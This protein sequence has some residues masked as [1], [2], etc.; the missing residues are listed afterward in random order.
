MDSENIHCCQLCHSEFETGDDLSLHKCIDIKQEFQDSTVI[1]AYDVGENDDIELSEE[2]LSSIIKQVEDLCDSI[3]KG[4]PITERAI[5]VNQQLIDAVGSYRDQL[6]LIDSKNVEMQEDNWDDFDNLPQESEVESGKNDSDTEYKPRVKNK[7]NKLPN[8]D[9][10]TPTSKVDK[11]TVTKVSTVNNKESDE[12]SDQNKTDCDFEPDIGKKTGKKAETEPK[13]KCKLL[14]NAKT[15]TKSKTSNSTKV[16][17]LNRYM[18]PYM[19]YTNGNI[20]F[21]CMICNE[22]FEKKLEMF[23]HLKSTHDSEITQKNSETKKK[24]FSTEHIDKMMDIVKSQ[25][26][27]HSINSMAEMIKLNTTTIRIRIRKEGTVFEKQDREC[28]FCVLKKNHL[29]SKDCD[30]SFPNDTTFLYLKYN[31]E[32]KIFYCSICNKSGQGISRG[33][34]RLLSHIKTH[35]KTA[36]LEEIVFVKK[37]NNCENGTVRTVNDVLSRST[38][39]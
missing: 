21:E 5:L 2:F 28:H 3:Q 22:K 6:I 37:R 27:N 16:A 24:S 9:S 39:F 10:I 19:K 25:C 20:V 7:K 15:T 33:R 17:H 29:E 35:K 34:E 31:K 11:V 32:E 38:P 14:K 12:E 36:K 13:T 30:K 18:I 1:D 8:A 4:D 23:Q 26:G